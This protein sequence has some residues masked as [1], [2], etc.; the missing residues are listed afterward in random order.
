MK[1]NITA[2]AARN[3]GLWCDAVC[4]ALKHA[5][6]N[7]VHSPACTSPPASAGRTLAHGGLSRLRN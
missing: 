6:R 1:K 7:A 5:R 3:N 4:G 2:L